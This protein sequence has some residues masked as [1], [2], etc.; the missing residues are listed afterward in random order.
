MPIN[1]PATPDPDSVG[2]EIMTDHLAG[3]GPE[4]SDAL[5]PS[6]SQPS[7]PL[8]DGNEAAQFNVI[9]G[10]E[11][12]QEDEEDKFNWM[13]MESPLNLS[14]DAYGLQFGEDSFADHLDPDPFADDDFGLHFPFD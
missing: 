6:S 14:E 5:P 8:R 9:S 3:S 12:A 4:R 10:K 1:G 11:E 7:L 13:L 2:S